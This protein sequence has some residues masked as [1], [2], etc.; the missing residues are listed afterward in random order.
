MKIFVAALFLFI[1]SIYAIALYKNYAK[2]AKIE[3]AL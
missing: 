3:A 1:G 2:S